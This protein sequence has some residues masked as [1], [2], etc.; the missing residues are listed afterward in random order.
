MTETNLALSNTVRAN[1]ALSNKVR[2]N[3]ALSNTVRIEL[4]D[5]YKPNGYEY[6]VAY[7]GVNNSYYITYSTKEPESSKIVTTDKNTEAYNLIFSNQ[8]VSRSFRTEND[9]LEYCNTEF[10]VERYKDNGN[11]VI[12]PKRDKDNGIYFCNYDFYVNNKKIYKHG[13]VSSTLMGYTAQELRD[14]TMSETIAILPIS[15]TIFVLYI[16]IRKGWQ[17]IKEMINHA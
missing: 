8:T 14:A 11:A 7:R 3:L 17:K 9:L 10:N 4:N 6:F 5:V 1:L 2:T 16:S 15:A 12:I 13:Y